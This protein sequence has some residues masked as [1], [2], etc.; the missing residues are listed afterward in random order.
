[1]EAV[2]NLKVRDV[3][4]KNVLILITFSI[5]LLSGF[6][7]TLSQNDVARSL[8]YGSELVFLIGAYFLIHSLFKK[9]QLFPFIVIA[10]VYIF[11]IGSIFIFGGGITTT[12]IFFFLLILATVHMYRTVF[13]IGFI[14]GG[15]GL[16][17]NT[18][19]STV[20]TMI[21]QE[22]FASILL[23]YVLT[24]V[25]ANVLIYLSSKQFDHIENLLI[26]SENEAIRKESE[27]QRLEASVSQMIER[28]SSINE[29]VQE[30]VHSQGEISTALTEV[31]SGSAVQSE[32]ISGIS[33]YS[34]D[35]NVQMGRMLE[36][37]KLLKDEFENS[38]E[39][40]ASGNNQSATLSSNMEKLH[41]HIE[42]LS[43]AFRSLT[44]KINETNTFSQDIIN[45]SEQT[46]LLAL[47]ASIEAARAGDAGKGFSVVADEIRKLAETTNMTAEK[48]TTNLREVNKTNEF[49]LE[50]MNV[51][52]K[53]VNENLEKA[54]QV[55]DDFTELANYLR[56]LNEQ[57]STFEQL[58]ETVKENSTSVEES[59]S[60]LASI[61]EEASASI[62]EVSA[63]VENLNRQNKKI[64]D[65]M[66][67]T[68]SVAVSLTA[69][70]ND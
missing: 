17:L 16:Y 30:N 31:A 23:L 39:V 56:S 66:K 53:M 4:K 47:N 59:T 36:Q 54:G 1:M 50:K 5:S 26:E 25:L 49:A 12:L 69:T 10:A 9:E 8:L 33:Q 34:Q 51:N 58:A 40:A 29:R 41:S 27:Q 44:N 21:L 18:Y 67:G 15:V 60:E 14:L 55:N 22:N 68:E 43:D 57:F 42:E 61:I 38:T 37:T 70:T 46:N 48:I 32:R 20:D 52:S 28:I 65:E 2:K 35:T 19:H 45:V 64:A 6:I 3:K 7:L 63:T 24:G 62:E 13:W 11:S